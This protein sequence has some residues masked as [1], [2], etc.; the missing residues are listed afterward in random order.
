MCTWIPNG[1]FNTVTFFQEKF[2]DPR[3]DEAGGAGDT[4]SLAGR[5]GNMRAAINR[6][7]G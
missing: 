1:S 2:N 3:S 7:A 4:N 5:P 6:H